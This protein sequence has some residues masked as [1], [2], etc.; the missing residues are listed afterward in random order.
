[1]SKILRYFRYSKQVER[2]RGNLKK[3]QKIRTTLRTKPYH[4]TFPMII[5]EVTQCGVGF[6]GV[7]KNQCT[8]L[9]E[10]RTSHGAGRL[11]LM[12]F[13]AYTLFFHSRSLRDAIRKQ[14][15]KNRTNTNTTRGPI[16]KGKD[17]KWKKSRISSGTSEAAFWSG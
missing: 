8:K 11:C 10:R 4:V 9:S 15:K 17:G 7:T 1:M 2:K 16:G 14:K 13:G 12:G 6:W 3:K 5:H